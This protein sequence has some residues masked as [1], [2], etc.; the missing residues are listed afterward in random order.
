M[1]EV[2][3]ATTTA[4]PQRRD[5][6]LLRV[7]AIVGVISIHVSGL[8]TTAKD[9]R[10]SQVWWLGHVLNSGSRFCVPLFVMVS[11]AL[12]LRPSRPEP[13]RRF[14][15]RRLDR[16]LPAMAFWY[17]VYILF[18]RLV[19]GTERGP[20]EVL[21]L[22]LAGRTYT[23]LY[24][25]WLILGLYLV[26]PAL[27]KLL[28]DL[29]PQQLLGTGL[30]LTALTSAWDTT[31]AFVHRFSNV[32]VS[33]NPTAFTYWIPYL[34]YFVLGAALAQ[35]TV[36]RRAAPWAGAAL[37]GTSAVSV[38][39]TAGH[40]PTFLRWLLPVDYQGPFVAVATVALFVLVTALLPATT[41]DPGRLT[42]L[43]QTAGALTLGMFAMHL[44]VL[45]ALQHSGVL[46][47]GT[48]P[49]TV[50]EL[51]VLLTGS[52]VVPF[53]VAWGMSHVRGLRRLV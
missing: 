9:L 40:T 30:L 7:I 51:L 47:E 8:A 28:A 2:L 24:F 53:V 18:S 37:L 13:P 36:P 35:R 25:F 3:E 39:E 21:A 33:A 48:V 5:L 32:D 27:H 38:L 46:H 11:G 42:R 34:G 45:Y 14:Y 16:L 49:R 50:P 17:V 26:T 52:V 31:T 6:A 1:T 23:A 4:R 43:V 22:V 12:L 44:I 10:G 29:N 41:A 20:L 19:V 15:R